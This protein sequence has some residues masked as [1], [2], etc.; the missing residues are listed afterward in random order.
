M[1]ETSII[2]RI[3]RVTSLI[4]ANAVATSPGPWYMSH[5]HVISPGKSP[6]K[7]TDFDICGP[8]IINAHTVSRL[9]P[10][11]TG[12]ND[13]RYIATVEPTAMKRLGEDVKLLLDERG[14]LTALAQLIDDLV[15][16]TMGGN[17]DPRAK[18]L[19]EAAEKFL[20]ED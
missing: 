14:S 7:N 9:N 1:I 2:N 3:R 8:P 19:G 18:A 11:D 16:N 10:G 5:G 20:T 6:G 4:G 13:M 17:R 15:N 12:R